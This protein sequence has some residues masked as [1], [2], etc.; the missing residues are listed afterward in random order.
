MSLSLKVIRKKP[1]RNLPPPAASL[2]LDG[3][4]GAKENVD[5]NGSPKL[6]AMAAAVA[7]Q[8]RGEETS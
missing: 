6:L 7:S 5:P 8:V 1:S 2:R 4:G 3:G